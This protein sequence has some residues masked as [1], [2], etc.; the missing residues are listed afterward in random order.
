MIFTQRFQKAS[1][2]GALHRSGSGDIYSHRPEV[3]SDT[4]AAGAQ[5]VFGS[6]DARL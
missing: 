1:R 4:A 6:A 2:D 3:R 5:I